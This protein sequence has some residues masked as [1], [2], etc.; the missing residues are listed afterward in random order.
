MTE[1]FRPVERFEDDLE[2]AQL[3]QPSAEV[4]GDPIATRSSVPFIDEDHGIRSG[5]WEAQPG[6]SRWE[7]IDRGEIIHVLEG[8]MIVTQDG[9]SPVTLEAG[10]AAFFPIGW[11]G[12]WEI[13]ERIRKFFV[14]YAK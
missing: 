10:S 8:R 11:T 6:L 5:V 7:F 4:L 13:Q 14:V 12:T 2:V 9:G 1:V 3:G